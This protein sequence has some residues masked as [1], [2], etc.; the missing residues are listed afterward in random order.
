MKKKFLSVLATMLATTCLVTSVSA[1]DAAE[2]DFEP[3][4]ELDLEEL[5]MEIQAVDSTCY[6]YVSDVNG[7]WRERWYGNA[8]RP[9]GQIEY[10]FIV[11]SSDEDRIDGTYLYKNGH[12]H[13]NK[14]SSYTNVSPGNV[15]SSTPISESANYYHNDY[16]NSTA[17]F[18]GNLTCK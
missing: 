14:L 6:F 1:F 15:T 13:K 17:D 12:N 5:D 7:V 8:A 16:A 18:Y 4:P 9:D 11:S 2:S 10:S 3:A